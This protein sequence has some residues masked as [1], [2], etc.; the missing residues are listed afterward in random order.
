[1]S[2]SVLNVRL[3]YWHLKVRRDGEVSLN[4]N[5][6]IWQEHAMWGFLPPVALCEWRWRDREF[7]RRVRA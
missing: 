1:M 7:W 5:K 6:W 2:D 3:L 4:L